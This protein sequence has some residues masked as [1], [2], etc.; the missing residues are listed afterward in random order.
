MV[1]TDSDYGYGFGY[2]LIVIYLLFCALT[3]LATL[4]EKCRL[5]GSRRRILFPCI[6]IFILLIYMLLYYL[7]VDWIH[8][9]AGDVTAVFCL[10]YAATLELCIRCGLI[11]TNTGYDELFMASGLG[12]QITDRENAVCLLSAAAGEL[13]QKQRRSAETHPVLAEQNTLVKS[14]PIRFGHVLWQE[15]IAA[16][17]EAIGQIEENCRELAESNRIRQ[18]NLETR[19]KILALQEKNR[20]NDLLHRETAGQIELIDRMLTRYAAGTDEEERP[21]LLAGAAVVGAYIKRYGNLL[22]AKERTKTTDIRDLSRCFEESFI[23]LELLGVNCSHTL[24]SDIALA[25]KDM[26]YVYRSFETAVEA[27]LYDLH[28]V[29]INARED[30]GGLLLNM[31]FVCDTDLSGLAPVADGFSREDGAVRFTFRL[32]KGGEKK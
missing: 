29:W 11:Q 25:T 4:S 21:K 19:R 23:N 20:A 6:P 7:R 14:Q 18:E 9:I 28:H 8:Y 31:E 3:V 16:L 27:C 32:Q 26:L 17:T 10:M 24:P 13:T 30:E 15:D 1:W 2:V 22:L 5:P 12:I